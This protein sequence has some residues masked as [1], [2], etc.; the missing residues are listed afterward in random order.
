MADI[1]VKETT[2]VKYPSADLVRTL[3]IVAAV[4]S[5][6]A[7][8]AQAAVSIMQQFSKTKVEKAGI[9]GA[10][11]MSIAVTLARAIPSVLS[12]VRTINRELQRGR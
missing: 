7:I 4:L 6:A 1:N 5:A 2:P 9:E 8:A 3:S 10:V 12:E 11:R